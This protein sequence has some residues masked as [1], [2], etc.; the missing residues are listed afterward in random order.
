MEDVPAKAR[1]RYVRFTR[2]RRKRFFAALARSGH[3]QMAAEAAGVALATVYLAR[4]REAGFA[5]AWVRALEA[6][7][8]R[9]GFSEVAGDARGEG[10]E[11]VAAGLSR[12]S[13]P[14]TPSRER[15]GGF[16]GLVIRRGI[17][18][19]TRLMAAGT[20]WWSGE[21]D[22]VFLGRLR[23]TGN[24]AGSARA[25]GFTPKTAWNQRAKRPA[26]G[27]AWD[28]AVEE[29]E[30]RLEF[31]LVEE[32]G[33]RMGLPAPD[34][35]PAEFDPWLAMWLLQ[36]RAGRRDGRIRAQRRRAP[37]IEEVRDEVLRRVDAIE[38]HEARFGE[39]GSLA[40]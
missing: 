14:L 18:G 15:E 25:A 21:D 3:V 34:E 6:A 16:E 37:S 24:V 19:R 36:W 28:E 13:H 38:R 35:E 33:R 23:V 5:E 4:K 7:D 26:F 8:A 20:H 12:Q 11:A 39:G 17:G 9:L 10:A 40:E 31:R 1:R 22:V 29:A 2:W 32:A 30:I 27:R